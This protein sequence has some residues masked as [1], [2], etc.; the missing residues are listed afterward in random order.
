MIVALYVLGG[1]AVVA[2]VAY[3]GL[4]AVLWRSNRPTY[5]D[6]PL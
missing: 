4:A 6:R 2:G 3:L 1:I 5:F